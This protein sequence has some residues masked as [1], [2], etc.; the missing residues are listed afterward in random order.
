MSL[1]QQDLLPAHVG[2]AAGDGNPLSGNFV[3]PVYSGDF[4]VQHELAGEWPVFR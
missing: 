1:K 3:P 2:E 4:A